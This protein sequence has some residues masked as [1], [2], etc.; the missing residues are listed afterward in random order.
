MIKFFDF[1]NYNKQILSSLQIKQLAWVNGKEIFEF[2]KKLRKTLNTKN[3]AITCNSGSDALFLS[4]IYLKRIN[5]QKNIIITT[6]FSYI[7]SSS[8]PKFLGFELIYIDLDIKDYLL[9]LHKLELFLDNTE[10]STKSKIAGII[11]VEI[12]GGTKNLNKLKKIAKK[13]NL[14]VLGDCAQS[15]GTKFK[16]NPSLEYYDIAITSFYP[17]KILGAVGDGGA[18]FLKNISQYKNIFLLKNNG[19]ELINKDECL[20]IGVNSR[21]DTLQ[22]VVLQKKLKDLKNIFNRKNEIIKYYNQN[23]KNYVQITK[24]ENNVKSNNY[25]YSF[26]VEKNFKNKLIHYLKKKSIEAKVIYKKLLSQNKV[27]KSKTI[28]ELETAKIV[29]DQLV[30]IPSHP[31]LSDAEVEKISK[32]IKNFIS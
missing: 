23:L 24:Y 31:N 19:H 25:I 3:L 27:L 22:S 8:I 21:L 18:I 15:L 2:E 29:R 16:N 13:N 5:P 6:P 7:A 9:D 12:F 28:T 30:S 1:N 20:K 17:T 26:M 10:K 4:L 14:W 11:F 32:E